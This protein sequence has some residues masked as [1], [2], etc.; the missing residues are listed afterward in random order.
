[1]SRVIVVEYAFDPPL[2]P[3]ARK[4]RDDRLADCLEV[5][6]V[7]TVRTVLSVDQRRQI[8]FFMAPDAETVR[9]AHRSA[10]VPFTTVWPADEF[11]A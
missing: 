6:E 2:D 3:A 10:G 7:Q 11:I 5:R 1:M 8:S 4:A 9:Y